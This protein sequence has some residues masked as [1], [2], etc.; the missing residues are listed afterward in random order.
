MLEPDFYT[1]ASKDIFSDI[2]VKKI[3]NVFCDGLQQY[4]MFREEQ[5]I[6]KIKK[7]SDT[8]KKIQLSQS[9]TYFQK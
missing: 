9:R 4:K 5:Y 3:F 8:I 7:L 1:I 2:I 6:Q